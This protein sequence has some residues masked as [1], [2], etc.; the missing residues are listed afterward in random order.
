MEAGKPFG[1]TTFDDY[2]IHLFELG[3][4]TQETALAYCSRKGVVGRG[5]DSVKSAR[6]ETTTDIERL[7]IDKEYS[8]TY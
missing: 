3:I 4:I 6:G 8:K 7:E 1:M 5:I 2:I